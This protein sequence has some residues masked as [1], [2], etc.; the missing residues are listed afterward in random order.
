MVDGANVVPDVHAVL[1][2]I[3][4]F[5]GDVRE[6]RARGVTGKPITSVVSIGIGGS[7]LGVE[8]VYEALRRE[9]T[10]AA[11]AEGRRLRFLAN[12]DP[13]DVARALEGLDPETT[14]VIVISK[15]FT[16]AETM[17]NA[18]TAR[19]WLV[20]SLSSKSPAAGAA[21]GGAAG[22]AGGGASAA[23]IVAAHMAAVST[24]LAATGAFGIAPERVFGF[25]DWVGGRY[26]VCSAVG[27]LPLA[28]H[29]GFPIMH[30]FL[31]GA[32]A[33][34]Q[35]FQHAPLA[36][37]LPVLLGLLGGALRCG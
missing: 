32:H 3:A 26:S 31:A 15:T 34:D 35:H 9:G 27:V 19:D 18:R 29:F 10:A 25:W 4:A 7:Y 11:A 36:A 24:N 13:V 37:N 12:V 8:F 14:L 33:V 30:R 5:A 20:R 6:G 17:L 21:D 16:T 23:A 22:G 1:D 28:L 2:R